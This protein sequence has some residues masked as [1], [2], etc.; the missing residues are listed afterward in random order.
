MLCT[1]TGTLATHRVPNPSADL[2]NGLANLGTG[3]LLAYVVEISWLTSRMRRLPDYERRLGAFIGVG[4]GGLLGVV[5]ALL[6]A[7]HRDAGHSNLLDSVGVSWV[8]VSLTFLGVVVI[9]QP[10]LGHEW[11]DGQSDSD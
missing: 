8:A 7:A 9:I 4:A 5:V 11:S 6:L 1:V 10:L 3:L 2:L